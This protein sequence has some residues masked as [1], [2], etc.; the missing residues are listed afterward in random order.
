MPPDDAERLELSDHPEAN[1]AIRLELTRDGRRVSHLWITPLTITIGVARVRVDGIGGVETVADSRGRGFARGLLEAAVARMRE[2]IVGSSGSAALSL[3][4]GLPN[5]YEKFGYATAGPELSLSLIDLQRAH[6]RPEGW[7][8]RPCAPR[9]LPAIHAL[10]ERS[11]AQAVGAVVRPPGA[12]PWSVLA[13][14]AADPRQDECRVVVDLHGA[15]AA[16][17]W[18]GRAFWPV[19]TD[20]E[21]PDALTIGEVIAAGPAAADASLAVCR[22]WA[23]AEAAHRPSIS[24]AKLYLP[25]A[26]PVYAAAMRQ[27]AIL[28]LRWRPSGGFMVR[29]LHVGRLLE[30]LVPELTRRVAAAVVAPGALRLVTE[31][32]EATVEIAPRGVT[33]RRDDG[34]GN[35]Q[36]TEPATVVLAQQDLACLAVGAFPTD[37][38]LD[39]LAHPPQGMVRQWLNVLFPQRSPYLHLADWV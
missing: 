38:L 15:V 35:R 21:T 36:G 26:S 32:G 1:G 30:A 7:T 8:T 23:V 25:L 31:E 11:I 3:L 17:A 22:A 4:F 24:R 39:R 29:T 13:A 28:E 2:G 27:D 18:R 10:Y 9:D 37:D 6:P 16:Y 14:V 20:E 5:F 34:G 19:D 33:V 12:Y